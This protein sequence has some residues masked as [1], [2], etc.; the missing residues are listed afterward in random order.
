MAAPTMRDHRRSHLLSRPLYRT[1]IGALPVLG[2]LLLHG[3][4]SDDSPPPV[5]ELRTLSAPAEL[6][7]GGDVLAEV[8]YPQGVAPASLR[9]ELNGADVTSQF[10]ASDAT[11]RTLRGLVTGLK[12]SATGGSANTLAVYRAED[13]ARRKELAITNFPI[14]GPVLS[15]PHKTPYE[16]RTIESAMGAPLD[17]NCSAT[18]QLAY[19]YRAADNSFKLLA[20]PAGA[21]PADLQNTTTSDG[22]QVP[23]IVRVESGTIN[24]SIYRIAAL[25]NPAAANVAAGSWAGESAWNRKLV[26]SFGGGCGN[27]YNQ[28]FNTATAALDH[29]T[30]AK[31]YAFVVSTELVNQLHCNPHLQGETLMMVKEYFT[32]RYGIPKWTAGTGGS[33]GAIQQYLITQLYPGLLNGLQ[34]GVSFPDAVMDLTHCR[35][36]RSHYATA[37]AV[38]TTAKQTAVEGY[39]VGTCAQW[40]DLYNFAGVVDAASGVTAP[41][42]ASYGAHVPCGLNDQT[43]KYDAATNPG[44]ARCDFFTGNINALGRDPAT[45]FARRPWDNVGFQYGLAALKSGA[46][47]MAEFLDLN[48]K[49]GGFDGD[50]RITAQRTQG[51][52]EAIRRIFS[53]GL[54]NS[55]TGGIA[56]TPIITIRNNGS[57]VGDIHDRLQDLVVRAR[58][59][60][61]NG[62]SDNQVIL[63]ASGAA[64]TAAGV[65]LSAVS[66]DI[67]ARWLD[68]MAAD[69]AAASPDKVARTK[70]ADAV[71]TCWTPA[72]TKLVE[73]VALGNN[74]CNAAYPLYG[75]PSMAAGG[76]LTKDVVKCQLRPIAD[77]DYPVAPSAAE[78][79]RLQAIF[80]GGVCDWSKPDQY[81][82]PLRGT[83]LKLQD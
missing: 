77:A 64:A 24:R 48:E 12:T 9:V 82:Q 3:C 67:M 63:T 49:I 74:A 50:G 16:C 73:P 54:L 25:D 21:R 28:G 14:T 68:A 78:K 20:D 5:L 66:L 61:S 46:I 34:A 60:A 27:Q 22:R 39:S 80:P 4:G 41:A 70:P 35:L 29:L 38:W 51:D 52:P 47:N 45:G 11:A 57:T 62:R 30:L 19:Y 13:P 83:F 58:L 23:Y 8:Q 71:D 69:P 65:N 7:T 79:A 75:S 10:T 72:G 36:L 81:R 44:G 18:R 32:E 15:G 1:F 37:P 53:T 76:P 40:T 2:A 17:A 42:L 26:V 55:F 6:V 59:Q 31:G 33:G 56:N 43:K